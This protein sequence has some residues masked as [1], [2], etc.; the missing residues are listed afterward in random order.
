MSDCPT[1]C[2]D[3]RSWTCYAA[4][5]MYLKAR[6]FWERGGATSSETKRAQFAEKKKCHDAARID[7]AI[8]LKK[9][10]KL[11]AIYPARMALSIR[12]GH[13]PAISLETAGFERAK[14]TYFVGRRKISF[15]FGE[16]TSQ[17]PESSRIS[18]FVFFS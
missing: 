7:F 14:S 3:G 16:V 4:R 17:A 12:G 15:S 18:Y 5:G 6:G 11:I 2:F 13:G 9:R 10:P 1:P 8:A